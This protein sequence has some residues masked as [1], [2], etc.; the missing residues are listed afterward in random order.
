MTLRVRTRM[1]P[2]R[3]QA[4]PPPS[5]SQELLHIEW[6]L[7]LQHEVDRPAELMGEDGQCLSL[8]MLTAESLEPFL[9]GII[10][11]KEEY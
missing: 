11:P 5:L 2:V 9:R 6:L 8:A 4:D 10:P 7:V 3:P 1:V